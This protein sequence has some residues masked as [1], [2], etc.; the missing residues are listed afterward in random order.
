MRTPLLAL[1]ACLLLVF[2][3]ACDDDDD[4]GDGTST[5]T[6]AAPTATVSGGTPVPTEDIGTPPNA[7][8]DPVFLP[9]DPPTPTVPPVPVLEDVRIGLHPEDGGFDRIV[10]EFADARPSASIQY[11]TDA[12][13]CGSGEPVDPEGEAILQVQFLPA[14]A[15]ND[16]GMPTIDA[17]EL[18]GTGES[19]LEAVS[20][21]DFEA[22]VTWL[23]GVSEEKPFR[24]VTLEDP[25]RVVI[26]ILH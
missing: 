26:D 19:I 5:P 1:S 12:A 22:D 13:Q 3:A 6:T 9:G 11:V 23:V 2:A 14:Q 21:C 15:H 8:T 10:F 18:D 7:S 25:T 20:T 4:N 17:R 16:A 24:V